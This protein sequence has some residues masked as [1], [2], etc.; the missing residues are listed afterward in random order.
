[1]RFYSTNGQSPEIS[2]REALLTG[3][4]PDNGLYMPMKIPRLPE[5]FFRLLPDMPFQDIAFHVA[6]EYLHDEVADRDLEAIAQE[7][8]NFDAPVVELEKGLHVL[9]LFHG[10][11]LAFKDF[12]AR[13]MARLMVHFIQQTDQELT[14]LVATSGD[15]GGAVAN[16]FL[17]MAGIR[18]VIL[19]PSKKISALQEKQLTTLGQNITALEIEGVFDDC[20]R[21]VKQA[22][23]D[24]DLKKHLQ[25]TSANSINIGR[26]IPQSFYY[27]NAAGLLK[28]Q[29]APVIFVTPSGN[30]GNLTAGLIAHRMGLPVEQFVAATNSNNVVPEYLASGVYR[31]KLSVKTLSN[32]MDVGAPSN[33][34]RM[35]ALY[36]SDHE[37]L[38]HQVWG[39]W[40]DDKTTKAAIREAW[41]KYGY[42]FDPH[43]AVGY[44]AAKQ[45]SQKHSTKV[46]VVI[47][48]T[49]HPAK[50]ADVVEPVIEEKVELP[51]R[52]KMLLTREKAATLLPSGYGTFKE[53]L[54]ST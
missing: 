31:P 1:M 43:G 25:L 36:Q 22:F 17:G 20:Q 10:P 27:F 50:F 35:L 51:E 40:F 45:F 12:G 42:L 52:L 19:Y 24:A 9:E 18:V 13:F 34:A 7:A 6:S 32:A 39:A 5:S 28:R 44:L 14:I 21:L 53:Y 2:F 26:L 29:K 46:P 54:L 15:T 47:L 37:R 30:F 4:P 16:G 33:F 8:I 11:T 41:E 48:E 49:A 23:L 3:L 38:S